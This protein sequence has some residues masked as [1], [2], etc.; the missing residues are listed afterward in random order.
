MRQYVGALS[1]LFLAV[2][3]LACAGKMSDSP[4]TAGEVTAS[5]R[6]PITDLA[7]A[8][9][10]GQP[11]YAA[12]CAMCHGDDGKGEGMAG[13]ALAAKP[14][15]LT[16]GDVLSDPDGEIFLVIKNGKM[17]NGKM[18]MP[19]VKRIPDEQIWQIVAYIRTLA[20]K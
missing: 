6:N 12:N 18:T 9:E 11:L 4:A 7:T 2:I 1:I 16:A 13:S 5:S 8:A 17:T 15:N 10:A 14:T 19:P 3:G 20:K